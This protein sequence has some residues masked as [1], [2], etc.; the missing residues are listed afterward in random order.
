MRYLSIGYELIC[1]SPLLSLFLLFTFGFVAQEFV[2]GRP[3]EYLYF[4]ANSLVICFQA[5]SMVLYLVGY[6]QNE[7]TGMQLYRKHPFIQL[8]GILLI[9][10]GILA[11][12][13]MM[14]SVGLYAQHMKK[15]YVKPPP[16]SLGETMLYAS[17][18]LKGGIWVASGFILII[19]SLIQTKALFPTFP[20]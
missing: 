11:A 12:L 19:T 3:Y 9:L 1:I 13:G 2:A 15:L 10:W 14:L 8:V 20:D 6:T 7:Y 18:V 5:C 16:L 4:F 17:W